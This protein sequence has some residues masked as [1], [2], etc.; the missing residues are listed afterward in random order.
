M[1]QSM[2]RS[3]VAAVAS[4][5]SSGRSRTSLME[6]SWSCLAHGLIRKPVPT[7]ALARPFGSGHALSRELQP[8]KGLERIVDAHARHDVFRQMRRD[9][10]VAVELPMRIVRREQEHL[11]GAD[12][13]DDI[14]DTGRIRRRIERL[15]GDADMIADD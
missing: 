10:V 3:C 13:V 4:W 9:G 7:F 5:S 1:S 11:V 6:S 2:M 14:G 15:H 8:R 12:L